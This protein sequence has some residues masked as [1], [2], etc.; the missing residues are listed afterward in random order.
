MI[1]GNANYSA[2]RHSDEAA[3]FRIGSIF[4]GGEAGIGAGGATLGYSLGADAVNVQIKD[5]RTNIRNALD[6]SWKLCALKLL[7]SQTDS[8]LFN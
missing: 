7:I 2:F 4:L 1:N 8:F 5:F 3:D 6:E